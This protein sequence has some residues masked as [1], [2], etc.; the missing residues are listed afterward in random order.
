[1]IFDEDST[2]TL[3]GQVFHVLLKNCDLPTPPWLTGPLQQPAQGPLSLLLFLR[4]HSPL[5]RLRDPLQTW[6]LSHR[7]HDQSLSD[8]PALPESNSDFYKVL[9]GFSW[10][11]PMASLPHPLPLQSPQ[12]TQVQPSCSCLLLKHNRHDSGRLCST[13]H[14]HRGFTWPWTVPFIPIT[15]FLHDTNHHL[16]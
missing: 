7:S 5:Y 10:P 9:Q 14:Y 16:A 12:L 3:T 4:S 1:M 13:P 8:S 15:L 11:A 6:V 2:E